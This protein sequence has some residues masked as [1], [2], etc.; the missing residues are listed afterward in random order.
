VYE[1]SRYIESII[2]EIYIDNILFICSYTW[3][4]TE[5][6]KNHNNMVKKQLSS[7]QKAHIVGLRQA[8]TP[9]RQIMAEYRI[10]RQRICKIINHHTDSGSV[11]R[12]NG[13]GKTRK[14]SEREDRR[15]ISI[16]IRDRE[17]TAAQI[18]QL[19]GRQDLSDDTIYRRIA[20]L[21]ELK[22]YWK[23]LKPFINPQQAKRRVYWCKRHLDWTVEQ[24]RRV[25]WSHVPIHAQLQQANTGMALFRRGNLCR[26][27]CG[28]P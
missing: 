28:A 24:W 16:V 6:T 15:I 21:S 18:K 27:Q 5:I 13:S 10:S 19:I 22:S 14:T 11:Q 4:F 9:H 8:N 23:L 1:F 2:V 17:V 25:L 20:E 26:S 7:E 12:L 3:T